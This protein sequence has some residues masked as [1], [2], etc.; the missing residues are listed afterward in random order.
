MLFRSNLTSLYKSGTPSDSVDIDVTYTISPVESIGQTGRFD[1][2]SQIVRTVDI[3]GSDITDS[4]LDA[5]DTEQTGALETTTGT[6]ALNTTSEK[7]TKTVVKHFDITSTVNGDWGWFKDKEIH[8]LY[9]GTSDGRTA[10][11]I[12]MA[13]EIEYARRRVSFTDE[14]SADVNGVIDDAS[15]SVTGTSSALIERPDHVYKWSVLMGLLKT[16]SEIDSTSFTSAGSF[17]T[18]QAGGYALAGIVQSQSAWRD[19]WRE[20]GRSCRS[21][22]CFIL[23]S[24]SVIS[25]LC[26]N[27]LLN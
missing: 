7:A 5:L 14:I 15:G 10:F 13:F 6:P 12:H 25:L 19:L 16:T 20:W 3:G 26:G 2:Q 9:N 8:V 22:I 18:T 27:F 1:I 11:I 17:Y 23:G 21:S 24:K 4:Q